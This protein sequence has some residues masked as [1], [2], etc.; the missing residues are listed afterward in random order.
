MLPPIPSLDPSKLGT[1]IP[2]HTHGGFNLPLTPGALA[3]WG[4]LGAGQ[5]AGR[6]PQGCCLCFYVDD[7]RFKQVWTD[8][9]GT[10]DEMLRAGWSA[11]VEPDFSVW[12]D[13]PLES[14]RNAIL[15]TRTLGALWQRSGLS[16]IPSLNWS[17]PESYAFAWEG[18][19]PRPPVAAVECRTAAHPESQGRFG[20]GLAAAVA[21]VQPRHLLVYGG[22]E[23]ADW[24]TPMLPRGLAVSMLPTWE[25]AR[26]GAGRK[27]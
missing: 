21:H 15:R 13:Q 5:P 20:D 19:P 26:Q 17:T 11:V 12:A 9:R 16:V 7:S 23:H 8:P 1:T 24:V 18:I 25:T 10:I 2:T 14:Q 22:V 6:V 4:T 3:V 27:G